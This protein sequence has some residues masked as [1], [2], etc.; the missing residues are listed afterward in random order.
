MEASGDII[1]A[2]EQTS[3]RGSAQSFHVSSEITRD[4]SQS[5]RGLCSIILIWSALAVPASTLSER[6][7]LEGMEG[8]GEIPALFF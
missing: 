6:V 7:S 8:R 2:L 4:S 5:L 3:P 1:H